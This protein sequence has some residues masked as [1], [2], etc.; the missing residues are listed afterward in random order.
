MRFPG[1]GT[2]GFCDVANSWDIMATVQTVYP[3]Q[4]VASLEEIVWPQM[5]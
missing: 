4:N 2:G 5:P 1:N 3:P